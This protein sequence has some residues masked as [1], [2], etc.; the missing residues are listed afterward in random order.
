M[1]H[2]RVDPHAASFS[3]L[4]KASSPMRARLSLKIFAKSELLTIMAFV[5]RDIAEEK[6][7]KISAIMS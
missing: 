3:L 1:P 7:G 2:D 4:R 5:T 6:A